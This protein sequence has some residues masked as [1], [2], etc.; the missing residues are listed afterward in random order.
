VLEG[1]VD[2]AF[3]VALQLVELQALGGLTAI[4]NVTMDPIDPQSASSGD[5]RCA[6][7]SVNFQVLTARCGDIDLSK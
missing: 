7:Q 4:S 5:D 3:Q 1:Q 6:G 2:K